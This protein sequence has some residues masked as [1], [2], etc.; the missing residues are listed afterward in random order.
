MTQRIYEQSRLNRRFMTQGVV[1]RCFHCLHAFPAEQINQW[2]DDGETA[3]CPNCGVD[4]VLSSSAVTLSDR[5]IEHL[6][7][8]YFGSSKKYT[9]DEWRGALASEKDRGRRLT[10]G[11]R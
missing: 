10:A 1:C 11:G 8:T 6:R 7:A 5:L 9:A 3:L 2:T 4:A